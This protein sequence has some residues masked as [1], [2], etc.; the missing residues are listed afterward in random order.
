MEV[1]PDRVVGRRQV[2]IPWRRNQQPQH[3]HGQQRDN[4]SARSTMISRQ[5]REQEVGQGQAPQ[6]AAENFVQIDERAVADALPAQRQAHAMQ[7]PARE[8]QGQDTAIWRL[9]TPEIIQ[10]IAQP[11]KAESQVEDAGF[12]Y[13]R[14]RSGMVTVAG[15]YRRPWLLASTKRAKFRV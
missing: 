9:I 2:G 5:H 14:H 11:V 13:R 10:R 1:K 8:A 4:E 3:Q 12:V 6:V 7:G 15:F